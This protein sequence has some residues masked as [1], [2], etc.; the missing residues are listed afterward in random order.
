MRPRKAS[1]YLPIHLFRFYWKFWCTTG[2]LSSTE[3]VSTSYDGHLHLFLQRT[4]TSFHLVNLHSYSIQVLTFHM[5]FR[6]PLLESL[7]GQCI[8]IQE[9]QSHYF[10][11]DMCLKKD[12][13]LKGGTCTSQHENFLFCASLILLNF[14]KWGC[15]SHYTNF[16]KMRC[17]SKW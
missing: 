4:Q 2:W 17:S 6:M 11:S 9:N 5:F 10:T 14:Q 3:I 13:S 16:R 8:V 1:V 12:F 7:K 15:F